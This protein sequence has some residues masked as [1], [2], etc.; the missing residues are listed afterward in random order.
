MQAAVESERSSDEGGQSA[1]NADAEPPEPGSPDVVVLQDADRSLSEDDGRW[2]TARL[3]EA[4]DQVRQADVVFR[5]VAIRIVDDAEMEVAHRRFSGVEGTTDVLTF[6]EAGE[7]CFE[8][9]LLLCH[10]EAARR[11]AELGHELRRELLLYALHGV[12]HAVGYDDHEPGAHAAMH[13]EEDRILEQI[14]VGR[15]FEAGGDA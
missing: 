2:I 1:L 10:E 8:V 6:V 13:A 7:G 4:I 12:L 14:G 3:S 15:T 11:V 5:R 9:D